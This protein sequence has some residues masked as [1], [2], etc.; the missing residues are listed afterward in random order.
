[1]TTSPSPL[2]Y[3]FGTRL[4]LGYVF[5][6]SDRDNS[7]SLSYIYANDGAFL[8]FNI[9]S[10]SNK[11][12]DPPRTTPCSKKKKKKLD[13]RSALGSGSQERRG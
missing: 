6:L 7:Y 3:R 2:T 11:D 10:K 4:N 8:N 5:D 9:D 1:M 12:K 13:P